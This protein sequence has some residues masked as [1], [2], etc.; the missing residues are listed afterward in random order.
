MSAEAA[1]VASNEG[2]FGS[3]KRFGTTLVALAHTRLKLAGTELEEQV[4]HAAGIVVWVVVTLVLG[5]LALIMAIILLLVV[6]WESHPV[7]AASL[8]T[9]ALALGTLAAWLMLRHRLRTRPKFLAA[10][11]LELERDRS[12]LARHR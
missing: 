12:A 1:G 10:T 2:V 11:L 3:L 4:A 8:I 6:F 5:S 9:G 7:L